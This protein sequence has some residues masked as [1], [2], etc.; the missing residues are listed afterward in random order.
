MFTV[1]KI[2]VSVNNHSSINNVNCFHLL[3]DKLETGIIRSNR[4]SAI[5][6]Y[7]NLRDRNEGLEF[8]RF[9]KSDNE[10]VDK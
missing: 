8:C 2:L 5:S 4:S 10:Q 3:G 1:S 6:M 9:A 7:C